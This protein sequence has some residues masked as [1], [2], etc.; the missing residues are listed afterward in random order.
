MFSDPAIP[1]EI[2]T[3]L[4]FNKESGEFAA[5]VQDVCMLLGTLLI[6]F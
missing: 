1:I 3:Q 6:L 4:Q 5:N 2:R